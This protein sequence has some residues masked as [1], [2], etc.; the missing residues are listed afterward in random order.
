MPLDDSVFETIPNLAFTLLLAGAERKFELAYNGTTEAAEAYGGRVVGPEAWQSKEGDYVLLAFRG[1]TQTE[2]ALIQ[3]DPEV[4][5]DPVPD[6]MAR[7][8]DELLAEMDVTRIN[9]QKVVAGGDWAEDAAVGAGGLTITPEG[10][11]VWSESSWQAGLTLI[12]GSAYD[13]IPA[14]CNGVDT[15]ADDSYVQIQSS[16][17]KLASSP[18]LNNAAGNTMAGTYLHLIRCR[19]RMKVSHANIGLGVTISD[20]TRLLYQGMF[21]LSEDQTDQWITV[22]GQ[23]LNVWPFH[24]GPGSG[25]N[26]LGG[27][28]LRLHRIAPIG[29]S[30]LTEFRPLVSEVQVDYTSL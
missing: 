6:Y 15:P 27:L 11:F 9:W 23:V 2:I 29:Y 16:D 17:W 19:V 18:M 14:V 25:V 8:G 13:I 3:R 21:Y 26:Q 12:G 30:E 4:D 22:D 7:Y 20:S 28:E 5:P 1:K 10:H 24:V